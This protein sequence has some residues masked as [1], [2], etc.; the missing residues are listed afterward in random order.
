MCTYRGGRECWERE[1]W[2]GDGRS[3][4][5]ALDG[6]TSLLLTPG[7]SGPSAPEWAMSATLTRSPVGIQ[8]PASCS[9]GEDSA[10]LDVGV[11]FGG[12]LL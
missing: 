7:C 11:V 10:S 1:Q 6:I 4:L 2:S 9:V 12:G 3:C 5:E 8:P